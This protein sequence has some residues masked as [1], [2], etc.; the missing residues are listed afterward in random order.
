[1]A[2]PDAA[3][4]ARAA[5]E[6]RL[7]D[8]A[9]ANFDISHGWPDGAHTPREFVAESKRW[10]VG[11]RRPVVPLNDVQISA[12]YASAADLDQNVLRSKLRQCSRD[13]FDSTRLGAG[14]HE[15]GRFEMR[16]A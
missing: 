6:V 15:N 14:L 11:I 5:G 8:D 16:H 10:P 7:G 9:I 3:L 12:A 2:E 1:M 13:A 4:S